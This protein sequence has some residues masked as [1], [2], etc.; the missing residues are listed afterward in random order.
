MFGGR[1]A[2]V[3]TDGCA[4]TLGAGPLLRARTG[5]RWPSGASLAFE[6][7][8]LQAG[9]TLRDRAAWAVP[10]GL[11]PQKGLVND[12]LTLR[13][14][15]FGVSA[16]TRTGGRLSL[17]LSFGV[18][19]LIGAIEDRRTGTFPQ[20]TGRDYA[21]DV[22]ESLG[23]RGLYAA[24]E[25]RLGVRCGERLWLDAFAQ[26]VLLLVPDPPRWVPSRGYFDAA[27]DGQG[28]FAEQTLMSH[29]VGA[30]VPGISAHYQF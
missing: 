16:G 10:T 24:P 12:D 14:A 2:E 30:V 15:L 1:L 29:F 11:E 20:R 23:V 22:R 5:L 6:I 26:A 25:I 13:G 3:C 7:G 19:A 28:Q 21:V 9:Q 4:E 27:S 17:G 8:Y 18:G